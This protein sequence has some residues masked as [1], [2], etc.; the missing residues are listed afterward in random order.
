[1]QQRRKIAVLRF[2]QPYL[3]SGWSPPLRVMRR[4]AMNGLLARSRS[5]KYEASLAFSRVEHLTEPFCSDAVALPSIA[6]N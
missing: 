5:G 6:S 4:P 2:P 3:V 1:V